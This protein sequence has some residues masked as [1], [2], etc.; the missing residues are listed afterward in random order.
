MNALARGVEP[1]AHTHQE[2][3]GVPNITLTVLES[4]TEQERT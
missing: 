2:G 1:F 4:L 3:Y